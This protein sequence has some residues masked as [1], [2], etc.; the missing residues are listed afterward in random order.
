MW[1]AV[2]V[3]ACMASA[4]GEV[5]GT[6]DSELLPTPVETVGQEANS[7]RRVLVLGST[8]N[9]GAQSREAQVA[10]SQGF[11]VEVVTPA[12]WKSMRTVDFMNYRALVIGDAACAT[13]DAAF[14]AAVDSSHV[15]GHIV[16]GN[17]VIVGADP[18]SNNTPELV[19]NAMKVAL[20]RPRETGMYVALGCA[21]RNAAAGTAVPLLA[22][23]GE[24]K[25]AGV[26]CVDTAH[27][28]TMEPA[29]LSENLTS[30][31]LKGNNC[32]AR[33]VFTQY[34][35]RNFSVAALGM[36][37]NGNVPGQK[38]YTVFTDLSDPSV[39]T[40]VKGA[41]YVLVRGAMAVSGGCGMQPHAAPEQQC[42]GESLNGQPAVAGQPASQ[43]CSWS[44]RLNW[45]GDG[46]VDAQYG[47]ECDNGISN[48][49]TR[50][51]AGNIGVCSESCKRLPNLPPVAQCKPVT[52]EA[53]N[54][55]SMAAN[56]NNGS[57][58]PENLLAGCTQ[59]AAGPYGVGQNTVTL[60]CTD[61]SGLS[62]T[63][64][65]T[66]T[67]QDRNVPTLTLNGPGTDRV[68]CGEAY[69]DPGATARGQCQ[70]DL[71]GGIVVTG[72][73][74]SRVLA[75]Y[76]LTYSLKDASGNTA[77]TVNRQVTVV[78][79][80]PPSIECPKPV[81][82]ELNG[83]TLASVSL[84]LATASDT[85]DAAVK[86]EGPQDMSFPQ[87]ETKVTFTATDASGNTASCDTSVTVLAAAPGEKPTELWDGAMLGGG[88]GCSATS[89]GAPLALFGLVLSALLGARR[90]QR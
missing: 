4:C 88:F 83:G 1:G 86:V 68:E 33:S 87:G 30:E 75:S 85:C 36:R 10:A 20:E 57:Y 89:G 51:A 21:Y 18:T 23:F 81:V 14:K 84:A 40:T 28:F 62:S 59:S 39:T 60:T 69:R 5:P 80:R 11:T 7:T 42:D 77:A 24:F 31:S 45:C 67:V 71:S 22:P 47:E 44:C 78:D 17:I 64:T 61:T 54:T 66:V 73:V 49:R 29:T 50:D 79:T 2:V 74:D 32:A 19:E 12:Q 72:S 38:D 90:R 70:G 53:R 8:V 82:T 13:G 3:V 37:A 63:C 26:N 9:G 35:E 25:V 76:P 34:P 55:C 58:D 46:V 6:A 65:A 16:D 43:T 48:G 41:P 15:W 56:I 27:L 52:V